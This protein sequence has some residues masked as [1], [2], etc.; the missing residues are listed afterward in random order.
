MAKNEQM[1][2]DNYKR[3]LE[4]ML[5]LEKKMEVRQTDLIMELRRDFAKIVE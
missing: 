3:L 4:L 5:E 2:N 1:T